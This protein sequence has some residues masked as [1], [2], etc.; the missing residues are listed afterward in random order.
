M[1][2]STTVTETIWRIRTVPLILLHIS[3]AYE[4]LCSHFK[5]LLRLDLNFCCRIVSCDESLLNWHYIFGYSEFIDIRIL[6]CRKSWLGLNHII[7]KISVA[8]VFCLKLWLHPPFIC[9]ST[10]PQ[11]LELESRPKARVQCNKTSADLCFWD[12]TPPGS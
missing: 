8:V 3:T 11:G 5:F 10:W 7:F 1:S 6:I 4:T 9:G 12:S 2:P